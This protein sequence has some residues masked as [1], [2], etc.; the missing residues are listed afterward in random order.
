MNNRT[1]SLLIILLILSPLFSVQSQESKQPKESAISAGIITGVR[2]SFNSFDYSNESGLL[3]TTYSDDFRPAY[4]IGGFLQ[5]NA[6]NNFAVRLYALYS[7]KG[8]INQ[9]TTFYSQNTTGISR[10]YTSSVKYF[11]FSVLPEFVVPFEQNKKNE[12]FFVGAGPYLSFLLSAKENI[13]S[14]TFAL[15]Y[16]EQEKKITELIKGTDFGLSFEAGLVYKGFMFVAAY[17]LGLTDI[18]ND[19]KAGDFLEIKN[20]SINLTIGWT[21]GL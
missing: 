3:D 16:L 9:F 6:S 2:L 5:Y 15:Q 14:Q 18:V 4:S 10:E 21:G 7:D 13:E 20:N 12:Y 19:A 8:G 17:D 11:Q 1:I